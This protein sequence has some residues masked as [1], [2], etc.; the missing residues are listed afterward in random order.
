MNRLVCVGDGMKSSCFLGFWVPFPKFLHRG[1]WTV[2]QRIVLRTWSKWHRT[3][4]C[5]SFRKSTIASSQHFLSPFAIIRDRLVCFR[6]QARSRRLDMCKGSGCRLTVLDDGLVV[7]DRLF[8]R[9]QTSA[10]LFRQSSNYIGQSREVGGIL[11]I[12]SV[13]RST[14]GCGVLSELMDQRSE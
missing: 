5:Q 12:V 6:V 10:M 2:R 1:W 7:L 14:T 13:M 3:R 11:T 9:P 4:R 8:C